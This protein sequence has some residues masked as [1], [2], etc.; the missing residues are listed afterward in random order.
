MLIKS[1]SNVS[2]S[3]LPIP[4]YCW[5][6]LDGLKTP[7]IP[8]FIVGQ[9]I[10]L[11][12]APLVAALLWVLIPFGFYDYLVHPLY[13]VFALSVNWAILE[14][15]MPTP[16]RVV[17]VAVSTAIAALGIVVHW[18]ARRMDRMTWHLATQ[19]PGFLVW[20]V[21]Y[22]VYFI[23]TVR[24]NPVGQVP[25]GAVDSPSSPGG[26]ASERGGRNKI[27]P[28]RISHTFS[29]QSVASA[30]SQSQSPRPTEIDERDENLTPFASTGS[31]IISPKQYSSLPS[32]PP[33]DP[34]PSLLSKPCK[35][36]F[37]DSANAAEKRASSNVPAKAA[38]TESLAGKPGAA[39]EA[40]PSTLSYSS[41][42][43]V[44]IDLSVIAR[45]SP[46]LHDS[47]LS[48]RSRP[49]TAN[50]G[51]LY[52][53]IL[54]LFLYLI[55]LYYAQ[56]FSLFF[57]RYAT[58]GPVQVILSFLFGFPLAVIAGLQKKLSEQIDRQCGR[59]SLRPVATFSLEIVR[60]VFNKFLFTGITSWG[61]FA[62]WQGVG[63]AT[64]FFQY[65]IR[66]SPTW[67]EIRGSMRGWVSRRTTPPGRALGHTFLALIGEA[68]RLDQD[69]FKREVV[70]D[71][72]AAC[73]AQRI[74]ACALPILIV[75][76]RFLWNK[77]LFSYSEQALPAPAYTFL[78]Q[79]VLAQFIVEWFT[80]TVLHLSILYRHKMDSFKIGGAVMCANNSIQC[81]VV[82]ATRIIMDI[83]VFE[84]VK[85]EF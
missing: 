38:E 17:Q 54:L 2:L 32:T 78:W 46:I 6:V 11:W 66:L 71:F 65:V 80:S 57:I 30:A 81:L 33:S 10:L 50:L 83:I 47:E 44:H 20:T 34:K 29:S 15:V 75:T 77:D 28:G 3:N 41:S 74:A 63:L 69:S 76:W 64:Q 4:P 73:M 5:E 16:N 68:S 36:A 79:L 55:S 59:Y 72:F 21:V 43:K 7:L 61:V 18:G 70:S 67:W 8:S 52:Q 24:R 14:L 62:A 60:E 1:K 53:A 58:T 13:T 35:V 51:T 22:A 40:I 49:I 23:I 45:S 9:S 12:A 42:S 27:F 26:D 85:K 19:A 25:Q 48:H 84:G 37:D 56:L 39:A 82:I 31:L